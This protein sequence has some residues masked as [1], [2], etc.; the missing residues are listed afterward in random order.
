MQS[1]ER[2]TQ[3]QQTSEIN[4]FTGLTCLAKSFSTLNFLEALIHHPAP[5][6]DHHCDLLTLAQDWS[7]QSGGQGFPLPWSGVKPQ[8]I[9]VHCPL[10]VYFASWA[11]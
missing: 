10:T 4:A 2:K 8:Q 3:D 1:L 7:H 9:E 11:S 5:C 6:L